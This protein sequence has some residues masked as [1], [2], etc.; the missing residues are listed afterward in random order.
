MKTQPAD[1]LDVRV[2]T[3]TLLNGMSK[4]LR[5]LLRFM[6]ADSVGELLRGLNYDAEEHIGIL[7][8]TIRT[9]EK[10]GDK[11][12]AHHELTGVV[13]RAVNNA[14]MQPTMANPMDRLRAID[15]QSAPSQL[16]ESG[17]EDFLSQVNVNVPQDQERRPPQ[18]DQ[19]ENEPACVT[20]AERKAVQEGTAVGNVH[21]PPVASGDDGGGISS[22]KRGRD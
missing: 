15:V 18:D 14:V 17:L 3:T 2:G 6:D 16:V 21:R 7:V 10:D 12:R 9:A 8:D 22:P 20:S 11:L 19:P 13:D 4:N 1:L 5:Q